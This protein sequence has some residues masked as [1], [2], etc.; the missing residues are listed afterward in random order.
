MRKRTPSLFPVS[1]PSTRRRFLGGA[2]GLGAG[3]TLGT[4]G[5]AAPSTAADTNKLRLAYEGPPETGQGI[6]SRIFTEE[7]ERISGGAMSV[8]EYPSSQLGGE[9][10]L[11]PKVMAGDLDIV[12]SS[13]A[14]ASQIC[15]PSS[16][17]S[18]HFIFDDRDDVLNVVRDD[19]IVDAYREMVSKVVDGAH[20]LTLFTL[21]LRNLYG[22]EPIRSV[23]ELHQ[24]KIRIQATRT[25]SIIFAE[26]G[27]QT[28][29]MS[30]TELYT[31]LQTGV[32]DLAE[33]AVA[34]YALNGHNEI[35]PVM[36]VTHHE[37]NVQVLWISDH[38]W[39]SLSDSQRDW[40]AAAASTVNQEQPVAD[41]DAEEQFVKEY[42]EAGTEFVEDID[43][44]S[45][46]QVSAPMQDEL[47]DELG[48][49]AVRILR[50]IRRI[51][52]DS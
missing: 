4:A 39:D 27:A 43:R 7:L 29:Q 33:N 18:L 24:Q 26:Y 42:K 28:V 45:F 44:E 48:P 21:P 32:V 2:A 36:S 10:E 46:R 9:G 37:G 25:E 16:I 12:V 38:T 19:S 11:L 5:C 17:F 47:A 31:A 1:N 49:D 50:M 13:T 51:T 22:T 23:E 20:P 8:Q 3:L 41:F 40:I 15:P 34:Y 14:N 6:A 52:G 30:F 35:S